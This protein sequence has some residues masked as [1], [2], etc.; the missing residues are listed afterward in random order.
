VFF[1]QRLVLGQNKKPPISA[2][3]YVVEVD[4]KIVE[5]ADEKDHSDECQETLDED[6]VVAG[7]ID[8]L[9]FGAS[10]SGG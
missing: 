7:E 2:A 3:C 4:E 6:E 8:E 5:A 10:L 1:R 9:Y